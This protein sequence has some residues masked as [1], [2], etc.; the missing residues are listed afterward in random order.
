[1]WESAGCIGGQALP[2]ISPDLVTTQLP[3]WACK[4]D[5]LTNAVKEIFDSTVLHLWRQVSPEVPEE[6]MEAPPAEASDEA[7]ADEPGE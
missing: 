4:E 7:G 3:D 1:M 2:S 5:V 6:P